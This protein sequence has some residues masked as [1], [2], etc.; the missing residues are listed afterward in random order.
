MTSSYLHLALAQLKPGMILSDEVLDPQGHV[1]LP[2]GA[3]LT[4]STI[5]SLGRHQVVSLA[6]M[7]EP[8]PAYDAQVQSAHA[9]RLAHLFRRHDP[10]DQNDWATGILRHY[11]EDFRLERE[12]A[13]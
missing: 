5:A 10:E 8:D 2:K 12:V 4:E 7:A 13:P 11:M 1:L 3:L 6:V 9:A